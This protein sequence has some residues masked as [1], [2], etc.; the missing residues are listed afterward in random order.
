MKSLG[1]RFGPH[2]QCKYIPEHTPLLFNTATPTNTAS[3]TEAIRNFRPCIKVSRA[4]LLAPPSKP[5]D[6]WEKAAL[7]TGLYLHGKNFVAIQQ[8]V[9][10]RQVHIDPAQV[11]TTRCIIHASLI[12]NQVHECVDQYYRVFKHSVDHKRW[13]DDLAGRG[14]EGDSLLAGKKQAKLLLDLCAGGSH[15]T[16]A[17]RVPRHPGALVNHVSHHV[18]RPNNDPLVHS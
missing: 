4:D 12:R 2:A 18:E 6:D 15:E 3:F 8:M 17:S 14:V 16:S 10:T 9:Q 5:W 7:V 13:K 11:V 1:V